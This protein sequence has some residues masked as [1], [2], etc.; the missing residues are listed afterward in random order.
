MS[1]TLSSRPL[2]RAAAGYGA[3]FLLGALPWYILQ[4]PA[5]LTNDAL[6]QISQATGAKPFQNVHPIWMT[7]CLRALGG[8]PAFY[9]VLQFLGAGVVMG[10]CVAVASGQFLLRQPRWS[11]WLA[12][13]CLVAGAAPPFGLLL[14]VVVKDVPYSLNLML[15]MTLWAI[16]WQTRNDDSRFWTFTGVV[17]AS[18]WLWRHEGIALVAAA[19]AVLLAIRPF[20]RGRTLALLAGALSVIGLRLALPAL[21]HSQETADLSWPYSVAFVGDLGAIIYEGGKLDSVDRQFI[22]Q[23]AP[24]DWLGAN[25]NEL[26]TDMYFTGTNK[27]IHLAWFHHRAPT[28]FRGYARI[29]A[30]NAAIVWKERLDRFAHQ[31]GLSLIFIE[32]TVCNSWASEIACPALLRSPSWYSELL[33]AFE[34]DRRYSAI[35]FDSLI[36]LAVVLVTALW[37][38]IRR[39]WDYAFLCGV[40][41]LQ[42]IVI[43]VT[44]PEVQFR[45]NVFLYFAALLVGVGLS[46]ELGAARARRVSSTVTEQLR[47]AAPMP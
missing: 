25:W 3:S 6:D 39:R 44:A 19:L 9:V 20:Q 41:L 32:G 1:G 29:A 12:A 43:T 4:W 28:F 30:K 33:G 36:P 31:M 40:A 23:F 5:L 42:F 45:Y 22:E 15:A 27:P 26:V 35:L 17:T 24:V 16:A 21:V 37:S 7:L 38:L 46:A 11:W 34:K 2:F 8:R 10:F 47:S 14:S 13:I 18:L